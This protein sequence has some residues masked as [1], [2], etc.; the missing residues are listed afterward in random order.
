MV[1]LELSFRGERGGGGYPTSLACRSRKTVDLL[2]CF[3]RSTGAEKQAITRKKTVKIIRYVYSVAACSVNPPP[4]PPSPR[5]IP[6]R[7]R[8]LCAHKAPTK[9]KTRSSTPHKIARKLSS[10]PRS[11]GSSC[12][13]ISGCALRGREA[14]P[15]LREVP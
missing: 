9:V 2:L 12:G 3:Y 13:V 4:S 15:W 8:R 10:T 1:S 14:F 5:H 7:C 11:I 6:T